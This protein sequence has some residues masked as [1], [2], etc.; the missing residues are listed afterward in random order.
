MGADASSKD[1]AVG[2]N[3]YLSSQVHQLGEE[4]TVSLYSSSATTATN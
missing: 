2:K 4:G 3:S 1:P